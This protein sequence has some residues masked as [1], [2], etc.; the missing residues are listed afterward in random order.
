MTKKQKFVNAFV[1]LG[2]FNLSENIMSDIEEFMCHMYGYPENKCINDVLKTEFDKK[3]K[4]KPGKNPLDCIKS[5]DST[6]LPPCSKVLLQQIKRAYYVA[7]LY[8]TAYDAYLA[9][10]LFPIDYGYQLSQMGN[11]WRYTGLMGIKPLTAL[12]SLKLMDGKEIIH[13]KLILTLTNLILR[14]KKVITN[15]MMLKFKLLYLKQLH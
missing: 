14:M 3:C 10:D 5:V 13:M 11:P 4:P 9:F 6:T 2:N 7:H 15:L 12:K 1:T 8:T